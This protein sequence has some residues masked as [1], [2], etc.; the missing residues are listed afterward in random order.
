M[1][2]R[3]RALSLVLLAFVFAA[4]GHGAAAPAESVLRI[5]W[6]DAITLDPPNDSDITGISV[7]FNVYERLV[8]YNWATRKF[9]P[10]LAESW[11]I[12]PDGTTFTFKLNRAAKFASGAPVT[13]DAVKF[14]FDRVIQYRE[15]VQRFLLATYIDENSVR[16]VDPMTVQITLRAPFAGFLGA[17]SSHVASVLDPAL[18]RR[19]TR[20]DDLGKAWLHDHSAGSGPYVLQEWNRNSNITL[21]R[22][23]NYW[24]KRPPL[25]RVIYRVVTEPAQQAAMIERGDLDLALGILPEQATALK[26]KGFKVVSGRDLSTYYL[27]MNM[28]MRPF[29]DPRVRKAVKHAIDYQ[30]ILKDL[31]SGYAVRG[32]GAIAAGLVGYDSTVDTLYYQDLNRARAL[33]AEAGFPNGFETEMYFSTIPVKGLGVPNANLAAKIQSDLARV[34]IR[35][36]LVQQDINTMFPTYRAGRLPFLIWFFGPTFPDPDP[37]ISPHGDWNTQATTRVGFRNDEVTNL[38]LQARREVDPEKR[39]AA[40][41][42][43]QRLTAADGPYVWLFRTLNLIVTRP[44]V[45]GVTWVPIWTLDLRE[46]SVR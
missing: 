22:N 11:T 31:L 9:E 32:G 21:A 15:A 20:G 19:N 16:V 2:K 12:S 38:I 41:R 13:A 30:G 37:I 45:S 14:S 34:N 44:N 35:L 17:V 10:Q 43:A 36:R 23:P 27:A 4:S 25:D 42:Q 5:G 1:R 39:T 26:G 6:G 46:I 29:D 3:A 24:G 28:A 40:Y 33:L 7:I 18:V 8:R